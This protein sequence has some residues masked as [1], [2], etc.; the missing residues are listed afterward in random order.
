MKEK[1]KEAERGREG[2][3]AD[4]QYIQKSK[5]HRQRDRFS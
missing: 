2:D 1:I 3:G 4:R 5:A